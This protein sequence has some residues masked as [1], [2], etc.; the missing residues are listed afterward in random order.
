MNGSF[1]SASSKGSCAPYAHWHDVPNQRGLLVST[2][3]KTQLP[4]AIKVT[5]SAVEM[6]VLKPHA[7]AEGLCAALGWNAAKARANDPFHGA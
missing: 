6:Q 5:P 4:L 7:K 2:C 3:R 1:A